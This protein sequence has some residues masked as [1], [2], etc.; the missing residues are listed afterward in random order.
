MDITTLVL[1][2]IVL[3]IL[4]VLNPSPWVWGI[5]GALVALIVFHLTPLFAFAAGVVVWAAARSL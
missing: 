2:G 1:A 4:F 3:V 5:V